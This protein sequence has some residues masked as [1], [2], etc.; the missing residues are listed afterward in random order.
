V[1]WQGGT[2]A[3]VIYLAVV[4]DVLFLPRV[5]GSGLL[6]TLLIGSAGLAIIA[7]L[8]WPSRPL[9]RLMRLLCGGAA[10]VAGALLS[11]EASFLAV[12]PSAADGERGTALLA[13]MLALFLGAA[14]AWAADM[15]LNDEAEREA[16]ERHQELLEAIRTWR[17]PARPKATD[18]AVVGALLMLRAARRRRQKRNDR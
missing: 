2:R 14:G 16:E 18:I 6:V 9:R 12:A 8:P 11:L 1:N 10:A 7:V 3:W 4:L 15:L 17:E 5:W 13:L